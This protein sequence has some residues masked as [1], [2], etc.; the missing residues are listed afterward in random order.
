MRRENITYNIGT[1]VEGLIPAVELVIHARPVLELDRGVRTRLHVLGD[2]GDLIALVARLNS[3]DA[4]YDLLRELA[5][6]G[7]V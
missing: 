6:R 5:L 3:R 1:G 2:V 4:T 7:C